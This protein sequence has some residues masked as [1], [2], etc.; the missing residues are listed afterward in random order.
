MYDVINRMKHAQIKSHSRH[1]VR[2]NIQGVGVGN[3]KTLQTRDSHVPKPTS[4]VYNGYQMVMS[5]SGWYARTFRVVMGRVLNK[6]HASSV[7]SSVTSVKHPCTDWS[8][9]VG[10]IIPVQCFQ[11]SA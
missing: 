1:R 7:R 10:V 3:L 5:R 8:S 9:S 2:V 11:F 6:D 4:G